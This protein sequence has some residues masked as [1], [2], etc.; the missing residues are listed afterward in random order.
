MQA[1]LSQEK[2]VPEREMSNERG[3]GNGKKI[4]NSQPMEGAS[5]DWR[6]DESNLDEDL[7]WST[8]VQGKERRRALL[9]LPDFL[10]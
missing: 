6:Y 5:K 8:V 10:V 2:G 9:R 4:Y 7:S 3:G 1:S